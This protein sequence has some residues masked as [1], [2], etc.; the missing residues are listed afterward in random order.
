MFLLKPVLIITRAI[1]AKNFKPLKIIFNQ[2]I[3]VS[4]KLKQQ[5]LYYQSSLNNKKL[6]KQNRNHRKS[7]NK[8]TKFVE[9]NLQLINSK[10][11]VQNPNPNST[12][13]E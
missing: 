13:I 1:H 6:K 8:A 2:E 12:G 3:S 7:H 5:N 10:K 11:Q 9:I 4:Q